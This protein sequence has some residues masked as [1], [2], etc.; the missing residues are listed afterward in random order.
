MFLFTTEELMKRNLIM[1]MGVSLICSS[2]IA[3]APPQGYCTVQ[4][5]N[6]LERFTLDPFSMLKDK[7]GEECSQ[8]L[9]PENEAVPGR[10]LSSNSRWYQG[11]FNPTK[12][13]VTRVK[14]VIQ[15]G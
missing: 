5:C 12:K 3:A 4:V 10:V 15:C 14:Q 11:S 2:A 1:L 13:S 7:F 9:L 8:T 6:K